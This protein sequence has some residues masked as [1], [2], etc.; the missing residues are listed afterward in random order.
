M[1]VEPGHA[2]S[3]SFQ[4]G[5]QINAVVLAKLADDF[6]YITEQQARHRLRLAHM[7]VRL[8]ADQMAGNFQVEAQRG[9]M[10][11]DQIVQFA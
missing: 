6:A 10:M 3:Q 5:R 8:P 1:D 11:A 2:F 7:L 9:Q 4:G